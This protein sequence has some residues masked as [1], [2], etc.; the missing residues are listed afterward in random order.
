MGKLADTYL[1]Y[2]ID[3]EKASGYE[4]QKLSVSKFRVTSI[5]DLAQLYGLEKNEIKEVKSFLKRKPIDP[6]ILQE[7]LQNNN[8][9][10]CCCSGTS[11]V[12][13]RGYIVHHIEEFSKTQDNSYENLAVLCPNHHDE[14][15]KEG[16][17]LTR[18]LT[19]EQIKKA[20]ESW[21]SQV[22]KVNQVAADKQSR[23]E[24]L[25]QIPQYRKLEE[26]IGRLEEIISEKR[27]DV[28]N[29][30]RLNMLEKQQHETTIASLKG[31][32]ASLEEKIKEISDYLTDKK[33]A[34][35]NL[36]FK[37]ALI[38]FAEGDIEGASQLLN[39]DELDQQ[40]ASIKKQSEDLSRA[41][42][43]K[44]KFALID[45]H[46]DEVERLCDKALQL[47][48]SF[49]LLLDYGRYLNNQYKYQKAESIYNQALEIAQMPGERPTILN[50]L[51]NIFEAT[52]RDELA[53]KVYLESYDEYQTIVKD[54][55]ERF[56]EGMAIVC[57]NLGNYF[58]KKSEFSKSESFHKEAISLYRQLVVKYPQ[59]THSL[60]MAIQ[61]LGSLFKKKKDFVQ[62]KNHFIEALD[63][64][65]QFD[66]QESEE[67]F[68]FLKTVIG[69]NL[70]EALCQTGDFNKGKEYFK[71][72]EKV[73]LP[74]SEK[75]P[76][77]YLDTL[78]WAFENLGRTYQNLSE[79]RKAE[80]YLNRALEVRETLVSL[81][82][83]FQKGLAYTLGELT[84]FYAQ[85]QKYELAL[86]NGLEANKIFYLLDQKG[87]QYDPLKLAQNY[88]VIIL[89]LV[90][91]RID[92]RIE[93]KP[94]ILALKNLINKHSGQDWAFIKKTRAYPKCCRDK[95]NEKRY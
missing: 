72:G 47:Y 61:N 66:K 15:H 18:K 54:T 74:L 6:D 52:S 89:S 90:N 5:K 8:F 81:N 55:P 25:R 82:P 7:L 91:R 73:L 41:L 46:H 30:Q 2:G 65:N 37:R 71:K 11:L 40:Y 13:S 86:Q 35:G 12:E 34:Q 50:N 70:G 59:F 32:K 49:D 4:K 75:N 1:A 51:A 62:A 39:E 67:D 83:N 22:K 94:F 31:E 28:A 26:E 84:F 88:F 14:A 38:R 33:N 64:L 42:F 3:N 27:Q 77:R 60:A 85:N 93:S 16:I 95:Y 76:G 21:E 44:A 69:I 87:V 17:S 68:I 24:F 78:A 19:A 29:L 48:Q 9:L 92:R 56:D 57:T 79:P 45:N 63:S 80:N 43:L 53:M 23:L 58:T 10:C 20:K 36:I